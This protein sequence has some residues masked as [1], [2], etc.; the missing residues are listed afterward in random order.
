MDEGEELSKKNQGSGILMMY[1]YYSSVFNC[2]VIRLGKQRI[3]KMQETGCTK[4]S[5][6][7]HGRLNA[8]T[9]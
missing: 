9:R 5:Q 8:R 4:L 6:D 2:R 3:G 7:A 1:V